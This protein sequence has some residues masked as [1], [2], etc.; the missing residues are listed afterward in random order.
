MRLV[1]DI[2][3]AAFVLA[4]SLLCCLVLL[5]WLRGAWRRRRMRRRLA[6]AS[7]GE[8]EA[9]ALLADH[10]FVVE[11]AQVT[12]SYTLDVDGVHIPVALR[13]D[14]MVTRG[15]ERL[16]AEVKTGRLAPRLDTPATRRQLLE[17]QHAFDVDGVLLID[18]DGRSVR[19]IGFSCSSRGGRALRS[20]AW[21]CLIAMLTL[22]GF[23]AMRWR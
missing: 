12:G 6:R 14:Y 15:R 7:A 11:A 22:A 9:V 23:M 20:I 4:A 1:L 8:R 16:I 21:T 18:A 5:A 13:A 3:S 2:R 17:Y 19:R 10:G